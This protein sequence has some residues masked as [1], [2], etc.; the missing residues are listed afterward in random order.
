MKAAI[1]GFGT[2]GRG[3]YE[4][5]KETDCGL[6]VKKVLD[7]YV[8]SGYED[9]VTTDFNDI[10]FDSEITVVAEAMGGLHPS[11]EFVTA[12]LE[13]GKSVVSSNKYLI[14]T[15][16]RELT[17]L[18]E[19]NGCVLRY[20]PAV[21]G[22]I[23]WL[24]NLS[25]IARLDEIL[26][27]RGIVN[28]T[29]NYILDAMQTRSFPF[30]DALRV[31][32]E[33]GYAESDPTSDLNGA[34]ARR[35][36]AIS[37]NIA[38]DTIMDEDD[39][40]TFGIETI[41]DRDVEIFG[42]MGVTARLIAEAVMTPSGISA[43]VEPVLFPPESL[44]SSIHVNYNCITL[45]GRRTGQLSFIGQ[46][47]G[48]DP[49]GCSLANDML[50]AAY[51]TRRDSHVFPESIP[52]TDKTTVRKRYYIR[53]SDELSALGFSSPEEGAYITERMSLTDIHSL[54]DN[55]K[56]KNAF[57]ASIDKEVTA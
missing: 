31:A 7:L 32:Q 6:E 40:P 3:T 20:T 1:L 49:T 34:D 51:D 9:L 56:D 21:G 4:A 18:A 17:E 46:G 26:S 37:A 35:K 2:V 24:N 39:I 48:K 38:F 16:Y 28:G 44:E 12:C 52:P 47:A 30:K 54:Y 10:L 43:S 14:C 41:T 33:L 57:I 55:L 8:P 50:D 11:Y 36:C 29:T 5:L 13:K 25:R 15:Y 19:K 22:G 42:R 27:F 23:P 45:F 53:C